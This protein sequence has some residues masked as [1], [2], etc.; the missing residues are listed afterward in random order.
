MPKITGLRDEGRGRV[1]V[2]LDGAPWRTLPLVAVVRAGLRMG[3]ELDRGRARL[4]RRELRRSAALATAGR[5]LRRRDL[6]E[7][8]VERRLER[9]GVAP[10]VRAEALATLARAGLVD[11]ERFAFG[12][13]AALAERGRGDAAIVWELEREGVPPEIAE[14]AIASLDPERERARRVAERRGRTAATFRLLARSGFG[15][16]AIEHAGGPGGANG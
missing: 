15:E 7:R 10:A 6:P 11:D 2:E 14:R 12:R 9:A 13:A 8:A 5:A 4:L 3:R 1:G 16:D